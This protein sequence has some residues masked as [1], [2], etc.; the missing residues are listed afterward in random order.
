PDQDDAYWWDGKG[1]FVSYHATTPEWLNVFN[2]Q[3]RSWQQTYRSWDILKPA[4]PNVVH[5]VQQMDHVLA[6]HIA[7]RWAMG[8]SFPHP[9]ASMDAV[10]NSPFSDE[11]VEL[12]AETAVQEWDLGRNPDGA[13]DVLTVSFSAVDLVG[14][15]Y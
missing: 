6:G 9:L 10:L 7:D 8:A 3:Q 4:S 12:L 14:H 1:R 11:I 2:D 5:E 13:P 15:V